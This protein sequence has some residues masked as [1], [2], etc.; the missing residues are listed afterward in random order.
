MDDHSNDG[1]G[2]GG[3]AVQALMRAHNPYAQSGSR[4]QAWCLCCEPAAETRAGKPQRREVVRPVMAW[5][6]R[7]AAQGHQQPSG[8]FLKLGAKY[9]SSPRRIFASSY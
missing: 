8:D 7:L 4:Y 5:R 9:A 2:G 3:S 1:A 6:K